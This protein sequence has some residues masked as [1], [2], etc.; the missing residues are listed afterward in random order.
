MKTVQMGWFGCAEYFKTFLDIDDLRVHMEIHRLAAKCCMCHYAAGNRES[1]RKHSCE[2][3]PC[4]DR[5]NIIKKK[6]S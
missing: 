2:P 6:V 3:V 4:P 1:L 5:D